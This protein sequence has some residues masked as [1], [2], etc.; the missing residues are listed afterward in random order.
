[1]DSL[2][3][4]YLI[5]DPNRETLP[6]V[7]APELAVVRVRTVWIDR[8]TRQVVISSV[9]GV[10]PDIQLRYRSTTYLAWTAAAISAAAVFLAWVLGLLDR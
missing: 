8:T 9:P 1:M 6:G 10:A 2:R 4:E 5:I 3:A 7:A